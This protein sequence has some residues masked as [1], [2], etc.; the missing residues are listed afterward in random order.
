MKR[1][2]GRGKSAFPAGGMDGAGQVRKNYP[3]THLPATKHRPKVARARSFCRPL[4]RAA[5]FT[6]FTRLMDRPANK[7]STFTPP[8]VPTRFSSWPTNFAYRTSLYFVIVPQS[9]LSRFSV[10]TVTRAGKVRKRTNASSLRLWRSRS[11][12]FWYQKSFRL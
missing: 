10:D 7:N 11:R 9:S 5:P 8:N 3:S 12:F 1:I 2:T 6:F 4:R